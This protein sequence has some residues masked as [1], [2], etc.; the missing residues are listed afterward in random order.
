MLTFLKKETWKIFKS[1]NNQK[2]NLESHYAKITTNMLISLL[3]FSILFLLFNNRLV[4]CIIEYYKYNLQRSSRGLHWEVMPC[5]PENPT[6]HFM[7][8]QWCRN[9]SSRTPWRQTLAEVTVEWLLYKDAVLPNVWLRAF[10]RIRWKSNI[11]P[12]A[13]RRVCS[14]GIMDNW[15]SR[16]AIRTRGD[17]R[18]PRICCR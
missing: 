4:N 16:C 12:N 15:G 10:L 9:D 17:L 6:A 1:E 5:L 11:I 14:E 8:F 7:Y 2:K 3:V 13:Q 18:D